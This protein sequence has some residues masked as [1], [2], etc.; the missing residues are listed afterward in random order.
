M[1]LAIPRRV[2]RVD[3]ERAE[4]DWDGEPSWVS[5]AGTSDLSPGEYVLVHAG[6]VLDRISAEEAEQILELYAS[7]EGAD[8]SVLVGEPAGEVRV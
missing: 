5:T 4:I 2:L 1:C 3:G 8:V 7:L 6:L